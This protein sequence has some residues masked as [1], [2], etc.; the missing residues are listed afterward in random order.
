MRPIYLDYNATTPVD[1]AVAAAMQPYIVEHF[2]NPSSS[3]SYGLAAKRAVEEARTQ[4]AE[5]LGCNRECVVFTSGG[6]ESNNHA[7]KGVASARRSQGKHIITSAIEHPAV[8]EVC[9][10]LTDGGFDVTYVP[11]DEHGLVDPADVA[12]SVRPD[13]ILISVMHANNEVGTVEPIAEI[14]AIARRHGIIV[15]SDC[16]QSVGKLPVHVDELGVDLLSIAG[17]KAYAPKGVGALYVREGVGLDK[18]IHGA[19]HERGRRAG[20]ENVSQIVGLGRACALV[21]EG[22]ARHTAHLSAM[23]DRLELGLSRRVADIVVNGHPQRRLPNTSSISFGGLLAAELLAAVPGV[24]ASAGA[25]CHS[26]GTAVS[27][28]L[29]AM[30]ST[31]ERALGTVRFSVGRP[32]TQG[33]IDAAVEMVAQAVADLRSR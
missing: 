3:H 4:V 30:G 26:D 7:L 1:S 11:V 16:A 23:R 13:T 28:V 19:D 6:S 31:P 15:H 18:L 20:T 33:E 14:C 32:T 12:D 8:T 9:R 29:D 24:A 2:G 10:H 25:A 22:L 21:T 27:S 17:H 5:M